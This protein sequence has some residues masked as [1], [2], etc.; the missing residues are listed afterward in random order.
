MAGDFYLD[1][2]ELGKLA[3]A[4]D[5][6]A[7]DL[8]RAVKSFQGVTGTEQIHDGFE[9]LT[10][11]DEVTAAYIELAAEMAVSLGELARHLDE[12][13]QAIKDNAKTSEASD[14]A[15]AG[16]FKGGKT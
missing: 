8:G 5:T 15:L 13:G 6:R 12:M 11:S 7:Y 2:Q 1:P 14:E 4:F 16:L 3:S 9:F 10:E